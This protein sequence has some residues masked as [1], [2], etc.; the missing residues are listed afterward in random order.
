MAN[1]ILQKDST[2]KISQAS[3]TG[4][5]GGFEDEKSVDSL[6]DTAEFIPSGSGGQ[7][8]FS[9]KAAFRKATLH[10]QV[11]IKALR[12]RQC[13]LLGQGLRKFFTVTTSSKSIDSLR[14]LLKQLS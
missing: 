14:S 13:A 10:H 5:P 6:A 7:S 2:M 12:I 1:R 4:M 8:A 11:L 9:R 3:Q